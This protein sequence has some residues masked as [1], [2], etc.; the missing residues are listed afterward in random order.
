MQ[1]TLCIVEFVH[2]L[3]RLKLSFIDNTISPS[4]RK[5]DK[6]PQ[7]DRMIASYPTFSC[8]EFARYYNDL[9]SGTRQ[10][11]GEDRAAGADCRGS[12]D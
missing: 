5:V 2:Q 12:D 11:A 10:A 8:L 3:F 7:Y 9:Q 6:R 1:C 4:N